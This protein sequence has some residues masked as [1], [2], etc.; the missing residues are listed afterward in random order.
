MARA[1][2]PTMYKSSFLCLHCRIRGKLCIL[3]GFAPRY[4]PFLEHF[5][6]IQLTGFYQILEAFT[7]EL[8]TSELPLGVPL[9]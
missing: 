5:I 4:S 7:K 8:Q 3:A 2:R 1:G 6:E 9:N